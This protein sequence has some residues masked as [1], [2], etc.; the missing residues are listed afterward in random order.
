MAVFYTQ[1]SALEIHQVVTWINSWLFF[2][3]V[4]DSVIWMYHS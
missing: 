2:V 4:W 1:L 3:A